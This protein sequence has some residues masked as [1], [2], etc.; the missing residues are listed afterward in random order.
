MTRAYLRAVRIRAG[1]RSA[2]AIRHSA[3]NFD[4]R[5][6]ERPPA[7]GTALR[8]LRPPELYHERLP[9]YPAST[10][11]WLTF[12]RNRRSNRPC[13]AVLVRGRPDSTAVLC[14]IT[15][16]PAL[17]LSAIVP[18]LAASLRRAGYQRLY[19]STLAETRLARELSRAGFVAR[20]EKTPFLAYALTPLGTNAL[21]STDTWEITELDCDR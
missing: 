9:G 6:F 13:A 5:A 8:P 1:G 19:V 3:H 10:D 16:E 11:Y 12:H 4:V 21:R 18:E 17:S 7:D 14:S 15:R 2:Q 20:P